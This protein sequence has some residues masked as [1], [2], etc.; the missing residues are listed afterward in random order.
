[1]FNKVVSTLIVPTE[2]FQIEPLQEYIAC[3]A[4]HCEVPAEKLF[5][6]KILVEELFSHIAR[7]AFSRRTDGEIKIILSRTHTNFVLQFHYLGIPF[8]YNMERTE[9]EED[10]ISL[11]LIQKLSSSYRMSQDGKRGQMVEVC[12]GIPSALVEQMQSAPMETVKEVVLAQDEVE[13]RDIHNDELEMLVQCLYEVFGYTYSGDSIYYPEA[14]LERK[15]QG[16]YRGIVA[17]N[18]KGRVVAHTAMLKDSPTALI[19][20]CG[21]AFVS[22]SYGSRGLFRHLKQKLIDMA[23]KEGLRGVYSSAVTGHLFTQRVNISLRCIETG[24]E[25][26]YIPAQLK[27][28]IEREG[29][30]QR[31]TVLNYF[32]CTSHQKPQTLYVTEEHRVIIEKTYH[33]LG[34][35]RNLVT[36]DEISPQ[37]EAWYTEDPMV[38]MDIK[39]EWDQAHI[40]IQKGGTEL[41]R[42]VRYLV[43]QAIINRVSVFYLNFALDQPQAPAIVREMER[44]GF[45]YSGVMP[46]ELDGSDSFRMQYL[47]ENEI[48][49]QYILVESVWGKELKDYVFTCKERQE[50]AGTPWI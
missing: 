6:L 17:I 50:K 38:E 30:E 12:I 31:Q 9:S 48:S 4:A 15:N 21:Q 44:I 7:E 42:R 46:Y 23:E 24:F 29:N 36:I 47:V 41:I 37:T 34:L 40:H 18:E 8:G 22:P 43:Q 32:C 33:Q 11:R 28:M 3:M 35:E 5:H 49:P 45:F 10:E 2:P 1:M 25:L 19:C 14:I 27:S 26:G 16:L 20:E 13:I 39:T